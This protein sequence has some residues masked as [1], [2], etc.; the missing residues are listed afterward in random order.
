MGSTATIRQ[1]LKRLIETAVEAIT[2]HCT[3]WSVWQMSKKKSNKGSGLPLDRI[4]V[5]GKA[6]MEEGT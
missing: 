4:P 6:N 3:L 2:I 5:E 1:V